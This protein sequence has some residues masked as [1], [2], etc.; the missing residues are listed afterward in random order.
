LWQPNKLY[1]ASVKYL[2]LPN[3]ATIALLEINVQLDDAIA[4]FGSVEHCSK[5]I[6]HFYDMIEN[7]FAASVDLLKQSILDLVISELHTMLSQ[8]QLHRLLFAAL[9]RRTGVLLV[10]AWV[11]HDEKGAALKKCM[12]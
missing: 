12:T 10:V 11:I 4:A 1:W 7:F 3:F 5:Y 8:V 2:V 9:T 6:R